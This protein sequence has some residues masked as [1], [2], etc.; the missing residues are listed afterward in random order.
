MK[1]TIFWF[2]TV[3]TILTYFLFLPFSSHLT[4]ALP[5]AVDPLLYAWN[6]SHNLDSVKH[7]FSDLMDTNMFYPEP[8]TLAFSDSLF[9][10]TIMTA[11]IIFFTGNPVLAENLYVFSTFP[12]AAVAMFFL[13]FYLTAQTEASLL[14]GIFYAFSYPRIAQI[15]HLPAISSQWLPLFFLFLL[16]YLRER[17]FKDLVWTFFWYLISITSTIYF[18]IFL[19]P[20]TAIA[21]C[22]DM[23][24]T[25]R[26]ALLKI[27]KHIIILAV[28]AL[29]ILGIVLLPYIRLRMDYPGIKRSLEDTVPLSA[30]PIDY[31]SVLPTSWLSD[32]GFPTST[33][34]HPLYPT[35]TLLF[36]ALM[37]FLV[38]PQKHRKNL[39]I[40]T[41]VT[42]V[43]LI[44]SFGPFWDLHTTPPS[45]ARLPYF[46]VYKLFPLFQSVRVPARFSI[47]V[48]LGLSVL[49]S[50][51]LS[52]LLRNPK[53]KTTGIV[54][55]LLFLA[56]VW[57]VQ[58]PFVRVPL[59]HE[60]PPIYDV[61]KKSPKEDVIVEIPFHPE[62]TGKR[63]EDQ[64]YLT[65]DALGEND[66]F[67][68]EAYRTY[69][70]SFH[71]K[72]ML[73]GY[74]GYFPTIYHD[75]ASVFDK[76]PTPDAI[77]T[78][79]KRNVRYI[80]IHAAQYVNIPYSDIARQIRE[81]PQL[82]LID[83]FGTDYLYELDAHKK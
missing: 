32:I 50:F 82:K 57:Q 83:Q 28:P 61:L 41:G 74:S 73:N 16:K 40:F 36:L 44:L 27:L 2:L 67:A 71:K 11:P 6:L 22:I 35:A 7:G 39:F 54:I 9:A 56:E 59:E 49:A 17:Q 72:R 78:L 60:L 66:V 45:H 31:I 70:S 23:I 48:I 51:T 53:Y 34:E 13:A 30:K 29:I 43:A 80:L 68:T 38:I 24:G 33:N 3:T 19:I 12:I 42:L 18:G 26:E 77:K 25:K 46:V 76:F 52:R 47:F 20:L 37:A 15:G 62:W 79:E 75:H 55:A 58:T 81:Y 21:V 10:Q 8:N 69:F 64:L 5:N 63:M 1:K 4:H 65:Y 14:A